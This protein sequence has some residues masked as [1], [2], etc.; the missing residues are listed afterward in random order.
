MGAS[1]NPSRCTGSRECNLD[2]LLRLQ[3]PAPLSSPRLSPPPLAPS[4]P[5][6]S[7]Q[8]PPPLTPPPT[9]WRQQTCS[10]EAQPQ[11]VSRPLYRF[12]PETSVSQLR[13]SS[14]Q[15]SLL[16][17]RLHNLLLLLL[18]RKRLRKLTSRSQSTSQRPQTKLRKQTRTVLPGWFE[19][20]TVNCGQRGFSAPDTR[21]VRAPVPG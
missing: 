16:P 20:P 13:I 5:P 11:Q 12:R 18:Q 17:R 6:P 14:A 9:C 8:C 19:G 7:P 3:A 10:D 15:V 21:I 2:P 1:T 4:S